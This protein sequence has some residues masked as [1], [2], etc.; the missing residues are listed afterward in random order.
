MLWSV[1]NRIWCQLKR[2]PC[3]Q[4]QSSA[5]EKFEQQTILRPLALQW[6][7]SL[8]PFMHTLFPTIGSYS[9]LGSWL[10]AL[11][12]RNFVWS[13]IYFHGLSSNFFATYNFARVFI[14]VAQ[15]RR[16]ALTW[17]LLHLSILTQRFF[18][19]HFAVL[20]DRFNNL[21]F[22]HWIVDDGYYQRICHVL[23]KLM[24]HLRA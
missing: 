7:M 9:S 5:H 6:K 22:L 16:V 8:P 3:R 1:K 18:H 19:A 23:V 17:D 21:F 4:L 12:W 2:S 10:E 13:L 11:P 20:A 24:D 14:F 15:T